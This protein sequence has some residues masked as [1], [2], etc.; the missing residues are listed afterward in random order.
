MDQQPTPQPQ[1]REI[2]SLLSTLDT[3]KVSFA[4][5]L[6]DHIAQDDAQQ[7]ITRQS[8]AVSPLTDKQKAALSLLPEVFGKVSPEQPRALTSDEAA[9]LVEERETIDTV[10][11]VLSNR[12]DKTLR[13]A[14][15]NHLDALLEQS[16]EVDEDTPRSKDGHYLVKS[17]AAVPQTSRKID[18]VVSKP[19]PKVS[20]ALLLDLHEN[21]DL[22]REEY[23]SLTVVPEVK[24]TFNEDKARKAI[25]K[26]P[27][28]L[29]KIVKAT[30]RP[31]PTF[32]LK[33][34]PIKE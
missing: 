10:L 23:L 27:A 26:N 34:S 31:N 16:G 5:A 17:S 11:S 33:V 3:G 13:E 1:S 15:A 4:A 8:A 20:D 22:T 7:E 21:G 28:L 12:K 6:L 32:T 25:K 29:H 14:L 19:S 2:I 18:A 24:R 30:T 9:A